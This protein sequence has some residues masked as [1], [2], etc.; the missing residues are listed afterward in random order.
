MT[1]RLIDK[2]YHEYLKR[3]DNLLILL[4]DFDC[5]LD[6]VYLQNFLFD[7]LSARLE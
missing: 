7:M 3:N 4:I 5:I 2:V 6:R 1:F